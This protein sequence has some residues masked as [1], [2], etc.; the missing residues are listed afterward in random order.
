MKKNSNTLTPNFP[1]TWRDLLSDIWETARE[2]DCYLAQMH[3][4]DPE[5]F[6][7]Y[8]NFWYCFK[9]L[10]DELNDL[11]KYMEEDR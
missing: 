3:L 9:G 7:H 8:I 6:E 11:R 2:L 4:A 10:M 1:P 5:L